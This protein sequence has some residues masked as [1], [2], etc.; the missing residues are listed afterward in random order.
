MVDISATYTAIKETLNLLKV[1]NDAK[2]EFEKRNATAEIQSKLLTLQGECFALGEMVRSHEA[3]VVALK[4]KI[5]EFEDFKT[6]TEGYVLNQ[7]ESG[8]LVYTKNLVVGDAEVTVHLCP[9][10]HSK[11]KISILQPTGD[12]S[13]QVAAGSYFHQYRC[14]ACDSLLLMNRVQN[15][16]PS[17]SFPVSW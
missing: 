9:N 14:H 5:A 1:V 3:E 13:Y 17:A 6:Q 10:C 4:A 16:N 8:S 11:R 15:N 12:V 7:L 2:S